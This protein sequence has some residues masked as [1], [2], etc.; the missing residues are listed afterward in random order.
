[1]NE[2]GDSFFHFCYNYQKI[3]TTDARD[4]SLSTVYDYFQLPKVSSAS[5]SLHDILSSMFMVT[6][7]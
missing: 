6:L 5:F 1:M 4:T 7:A 3:S 2:T